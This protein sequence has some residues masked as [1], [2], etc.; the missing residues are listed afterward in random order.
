MTDLEKL[1]V[2]SHTLTV[3]FTNG[4]ASATFKV[5]AANSTEVKSPETGDNG[6]LSTLVITLALAASF[7]L[8]A[9]YSFGKVKKIYHK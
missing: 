9:L 2:G 3:H 8:C 1:S 5:L 4:E 7:G 6:S